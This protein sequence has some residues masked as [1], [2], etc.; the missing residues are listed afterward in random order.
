LDLPPQWAAFKEVLVDAKVGADPAT[1][2]LYDKFELKQL[3]YQIVAS[4]LVVAGFLSEVHGADAM[5]AAS[6]DELEC[7]IN[8]RG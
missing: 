5:F 1:A 8:H 2:E 3:L 6:S 7:G 4:L